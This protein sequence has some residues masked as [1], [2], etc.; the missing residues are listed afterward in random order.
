MRRSWRRVTAAPADSFP[1]AFTLA[2]GAGMGAPLL[3]T[4]WAGLRAPATSVNS[5]NDVAG[6]WLTGWSAS[7]RTVPEV[8]HEALHLLLGVLLA[9]AL[10]LLAIALVVAL[11][12]VVARGVRRR[13]EIALR[14]ALGGVRARLVRQLAREGAPLLLGAIAGGLAI[15]LAVAFVALRSWPGRAAVAWAP[16]LDPSSTALA[17]TAVVF[18]P[19]LAW[20][21]PARVG[22]RRDL[23]RFLV[24]GDRVTASP[25]ETLVRKIVAAGQLAA[26]LFILIG[27]GM[28][29]RGFAPAPPAGLA[30]DTGN[31]LVAHL[32]LPSGTMSPQERARF[33][34]SARE[35]LNA[36]PGVID[37]SIVTPGTWVRLGDRDAT[38]GLTGNPVQ[39]GWVRPASYHAIGPG[40]FRAMGLPIRH[41]REFVVADTAGAAP[42]AIVNQAF[43]TRFRLVGNGVGRE[44]QLHGLSLDAPFH[45]IVGVVDDWPA[46]AVGT[47]G[48][49]GPAIYL[50]AL[51]H[52]PTV[53]TLAVHTGA[54]PASLLPAIE[55]VISSLAPAATLGAVTTMALYFEEL[56]APLRWFAAMFGILAFAALLL[57][58]IGL[59]TL[60]A[61]NVSR[62]TREIGIRLALGAR[63]AEVTR[64][65]LGESLRVTAVGAVLGLMGAVALA[66]LLQLR[67]SGVEPLD[68]LLFGGIGALLTC[69][70]LAAS[71]RPARRAARVDP[72]TSLRAE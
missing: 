16:S 55:E 72:Q 15:G 40:S 69:I 68:P 20:L 18:L 3:G 28:L 42:V 64:M 49:P 13:P 47:A 23:R 11:T 57:A 8:Q 70:A 22:S 14:A 63:P 54:T 65:V 59:H 2:L 71:Y 32:A 66:R 52:P 48:E 37:T 27:A 4:A 38:H 51:Q 26:S 43:V 33:F 60:M 50:S 41:G 53:V 6:E 56:R 45:T 12:L 46:E 36:L 1:L 9:F 67:F 17:A 29:L 39:P 58:A 61:A 19:L 10:C 34:A 44:I 35:R 30:I 21:A 7:R 25:G 31:T 5:A 24:V 62:R